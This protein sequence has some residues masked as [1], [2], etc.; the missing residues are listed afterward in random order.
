ME[1]SVNE[2]AVSNYI[3]I[4]SKKGRR[5]VILS[6]NSISHLVADVKCTVEFEE[7]CVVEI[8]LVG[9]DT[10]AF[11][12]IYRSPTPSD[13]S[14]DNNDKLNDLLK[15]ITSNKRYTHKCI[16]GDFN[17]PSINWSNWTT[18]HNEESKEEKF[19]EAVRDSFL[20]QH[21]KEP[22]RCRGT[23]EPSTIDLIFTGENNQITGLRYLSPLGKSDHS[24]LSFH[25]TCYAERKSSSKR[26][27][28]NEGD[29]MA[30]KNYLAAQ[31]WT[32]QFL[33]QSEKKSVEEIWHK[34]KNDLIDLRNRFVPLKDVGNTFWKRK[35]RIPINR[36]LQTI[37]KEK[38]RLHRKWLKSSPIHRPEIRRK[39]TSARNKVNQKMREAR[40][41]YERDVCNKSKENPKRFWSHVRSKLHS[42]SGVSPLLE[43][44]NDGS[45][46]KHDDY[47]KANIL[48]K[49]FC[50]V[51][52]KERTV[53]FPIS[54]QER[55]RKSKSILP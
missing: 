1:Y 34:F 20:Y 18:S 12:C 33:E 25:F 45:S 7:A 13:L 9:N 16:V 22:T 32:K 24:V 53:T 30:M 43:S 42:V 49:Q 38:R 46:L 14:K 31:D 35:G 47:D 3:N 28:Y 4:N 52:T 6:H 55:I 29:F 17:F 21:V 44:E 36:E 41:N 5:I 51:F 50:S 10:L 27:I 37:I 26:H 2:Y 11:A 54:P 15:S 40:R 19:L 39:Y 48:Q 8:H 23:D